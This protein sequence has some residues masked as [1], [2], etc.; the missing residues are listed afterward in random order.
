M[1]AP[2]FRLSNLNLKSLAKCRPVDLHYD[3]LPAHRHSE[4]S[5][6]RPVFWKA[7]PDLIQRIVRNKSNKPYCACS[8]VNHRSPRTIRSGNFDGRNTLKR[9]NSANLLTLKGSCL[10][11]SSVKYQRRILPSH[12]RVSCLSARMDSPPRI[13]KIAAGNAHPRFPDLLLRQ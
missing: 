1:Q 11:R 12:S 6:L 13:G 2:R 7:K 5:N 8:D 3:H 4:T 9:A 10:L